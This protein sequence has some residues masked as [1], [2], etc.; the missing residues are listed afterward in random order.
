MFSSGLRVKGQYLLP[1]FACPFHR[2][3]PRPYQNRT[4]IGDRMP[5]DL[6][7]WAPKRGA[8]EPIVPMP[9]WGATLGR[10]LLMRC[11]VC[12]RAP[13]FRGF[14]TV[15]EACPSCGAPLGRVPCDLLPPYITIVIGLAVIGVVMAFGDRGAAQGK[16]LGYAASLEIFIPVA[17]IL[18]LALLRPIKGLVLA[19]MLKLSIISLP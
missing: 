5:T 7:K 11:P 2:P 18:S 3:S 15:R 10:G 9:G 16:G 17:I 19:Y 14:V 12:G 1:N 8:E 4:R 6:W 13:A